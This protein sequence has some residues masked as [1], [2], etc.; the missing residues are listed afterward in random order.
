MV[1]K[2]N[3][4]SALL[5]PG[6]PSLLRRIA[7]ELPNIGYERVAIVEKFGTVRRMFEATEEEWRNLEGIGKVTAKNCWEALHDVL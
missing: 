7:I 1:N 3:P 6:K 5:R 4:P 2:I